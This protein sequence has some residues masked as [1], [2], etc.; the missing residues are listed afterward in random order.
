VSLTRPTNPQQ[1]GAAALLPR[2]SREA[3]SG[4]RETVSVGRLR[5]RDR[6][7]PH[8]ARSMSVVGGI[9]LQPAVR[10]R[11]SLRQRSVRALKLNSSAQSPHERLP[12]DPSAPATERA[13]RGAIH[14]S[15]AARSARASRASFSAVLF[16]PRKTS[17]ATT[18]ILTALGRATPRAIRASERT[19]T[20]TCGA[21]PS[22][23]SPRRRIRAVS[24]SFRRRRCC[25]E[26]IL[27]SSGDQARRWL[28]RTRLLLFF[29]NKGVK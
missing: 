2:A 7:H 6:W 5:R 28:V 8:I 11:G 17:S 27:G 1:P 10:G 16:R 25:A 21:W 24:S 4:E 12:R 9:W 14:P 23:W 29:P 3:V 15:T 22:Q 26:S 13:T 19:E 20:D 18:T